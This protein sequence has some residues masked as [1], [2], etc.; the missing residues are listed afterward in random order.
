M[1]TGS[2]AQAKTLSVDTASFR[3]MEMAQVPEE[4]GFRFQHGA[5][6]QSLPEFR[7]TIEHAPEGVVW[8]HRAH[9]AP[10]LRDILHELPLARRLEAL[11]A[12][13]PA[14]DVYRELVLDLTRKRL[15][16]LLASP[17]R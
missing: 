8:Y 6:A 9:F 1:V 13:P 16:E 4:R 3:T 14:P 2:S 12:A 15:D 7:A 11:A 5:L 10:W 17:S